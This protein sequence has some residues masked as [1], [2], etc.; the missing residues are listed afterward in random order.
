[1]ETAYS[2]VIL[3]GGEC[4]WCHRTIEREMVPSDETV[5]WN[6]GNSCVCTNCVQHAETYERALMNDAGVC[7]LCGFERSTDEVG[8]MAEQDAMIAAICEARAV[9]AA[10]AV[11]AN[12][13]RE[14]ALCAKYGMTREQAYA[15]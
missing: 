14:E 9:D 5:F 8:P 15:V 4:S 1:M 13:K 11:E 10:R 6:V 7:D 2:D 12:I 3:M